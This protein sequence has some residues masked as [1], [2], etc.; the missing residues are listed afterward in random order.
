MKILLCHNFYQSRG[1]EAQAVL[2]AKE[3]LEKKGHDVIF[4]YRD[5]TEINELNLIKKI[6]L[7][8]K[9]SIVEYVYIL[10]QFV[11]F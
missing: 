5:N 1:G 4:F 10:L 11:L 7:F 6:K 2:A 9:K 3:L 8:F